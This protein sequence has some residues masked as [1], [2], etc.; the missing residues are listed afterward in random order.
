MNLELG[1]MA[2]GA[3]VGERHM[4]RF[5]EVLFRDIW[6]ELERVY[7]NARSR[8]DN[9]DEPPW[10]DY[11][12]VDPEIPG[13]TIHS[14]WW[15]D[16]DAPERCR[17]NFSAC[18]VDIWWYKYSFRS[19]TCSVLDG[20]RDADAWVAWHTRVLAIIKAWELSEEA[21]AT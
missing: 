17:P 15:G 11:G 19:M 20:P 2:F 16:D 18:G 9:A 8:R 6:L 3:P 10:S 4:P 5:A 1:Q 21:M 14:Y 12:A 13:I 7:E